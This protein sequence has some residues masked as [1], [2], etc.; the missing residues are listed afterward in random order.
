LSLD[1]AMQSPNQAYAQAVREK[2]ERAEEGPKKAAAREHLRAA[3][4]AKLARN[5]AD[6]I[7]GIERAARALE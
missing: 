3:Q 5:E 7:L 2:F 4:A 6:W 1:T